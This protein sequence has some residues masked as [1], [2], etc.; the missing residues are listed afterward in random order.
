MARWP[1]RSIALFALMATIWSALGLA[2]VDGTSATPGLPSGSC[3]SYQY[4]CVGGGYAASAAT[5]GNGWA[6]RYYGEVGA[7]GIGTPSGPH[8]CT[9]YV[10]WRLQQNGMADPGRS[11][12]NASRWGT[13]LPSNHTPAIGA[14]AWWQS[15]NHVAYVEQ[16]S[17]DGS[18]VRVTADN[19]V[20][21]G[22]G[23]YTDS[24]WISV[25]APTGYLHP[26]DIGD[27][28]GGIT[29]GSF[30]SFGGHVYRIAGGAPLY[31]S[32]WN[33]FGGPQPTTGLTAQQFNALAP[34]PAD[35]T[36]VSA[37]DGAVYVFTG[38]APL[39]VSNWAAIGGARPSIKV[40]QWTLDRAG[41]AAP[42]DH[43][44]RYPVDGAAVSAAEGAVYVFAGGAP[45]YVSNWAAIGGPRPTTRVDQF[46]LDQGGN[47]GFPFGHVRK[48]PADGTLVSAA[49]GAVSVFAGGAPLYV[50]DFANIGG[51]NGRPVTNVDQA[52]LDQGGNNAFPWGHVRK[53][54]ADGTLVSAAQG[55]VSVFAG[56]APLYVTDFANIG[57]QNGRPVTNVD[58]AA[59]DQGGN[60]AF[61][62]GH[63]RRYPADG[64]A[65]ATQTTANYLVAGG[66]AI[67]VS[68]WSALGGTPGLVAVDQVVIDQS[69]NTQFP[70]G[71]LSPVPVD[72]TVIRFLPSGRTVT[73]GDGRCAPTDQ[74]AAVSVN[75]GAWSCGTA[76]QAPSVTSTRP[77]P[78]SMRVAFRGGADGGNP[79]TGYS[80]T[81]NSTDGGPT[82]T[83]TGATSPIS[84]TG[85]TALKT[86]RCRVRA[87]NAIGTSRWSP[88]GETVLLPLTAPAAPSVTGST[89]QGSAASVAFTPGADGGSP[90]TGYFAQ[91]ESTDGGLTKSNTRTTSPITVTGLTPGKNYHCRTRATNAFGSSPYSG[92]GP[93]VTVPAT[94]PAAPTVTGTTRQGSSALVTLTAA[95][96][97]GSPI[98]GYLARC[99]SDGGT[100]RN[101]TGTASPIT[102]MGLS[103]G[104]SYHCRVRATNA[105]GSG[106]YSGYGSTVTV[107]ATAPAA[108]T[109]T[110]TTLHG[111]GATVTVAPGSDG[112]SP[113]TGYL[114]RCESTDG[115]TTRN[116]TGTTSPVSVT[117]LSPGKSYHCRTRATNAI[118][119]SPYSGYG[120][121]ITLPA[122]AARGFTR[123]RVS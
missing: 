15:G 14:V 45:L 39:Y 90:V 8:N 42:N 116:A 58:Q 67:T 57:G 54:P 72:G 114:A 27:S 77:A 121:T 65:L 88:Y 112:G 70:W 102:V 78:S 117:G 34:Y 43:L 11:W 53:N 35:G 36:T 64:T 100:T 98:T 118:G 16:I 101:A 61:P 44:R 83:S 23:G 94:A 26:H 75:D 104:K 28:G 60:N 46:A 91:C 51:Q 80:A 48:N 81:C 109:V 63:V 113:I 69:S 84:V 37:R 24:G 105:V 18:Q 9:L 29:D 96:D 106:P 19:Y 40:D 38:G 123:K 82:K 52:A 93:T 108:P 32:S 47:D 31:V 79:I 107:P 41:E 62:W 68:D 30:V 76:P 33:V 95:S 5:T 99:E 17:A 115:G 3:R 4:A 59:L 7:G 92:Y 20:P 87:T 6:W 56:G 74:S 103:P 66:T 73:F 86:Y 71:H 49:Q 12:G 1:A 21:T 111:T 89:P 85:L 10:A 22:A 120:P 119:S 122:I 50:T 110:G 25:N 55:A 13:N 97:G 2:I